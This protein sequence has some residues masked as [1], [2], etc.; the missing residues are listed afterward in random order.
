ML[1]VLPR[2]ARTLAQAGAPPSSILLVEHDADRA[3]A[4]TRSLEEAN[5]R[6]VRC[7][8][9]Q[10][11]QELLDREVPD[12][13]LLATSLPDGDGTTVARIVREDP[14]FRM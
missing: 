5:I 12:L 10:S 4:V 11:V 9:A 7:A 3:A 1:E 8:L 2:Y 6:V 13:M 14:R